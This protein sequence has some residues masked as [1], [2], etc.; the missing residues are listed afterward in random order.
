MDQNQPNVSATKLRV[1]EISGRPFGFEVS[2][3]RGKLYL[4][5]RE[6]YNPDPDSHG[7]ATLEEAAKHL[8]FGGNGVSIRVDGELGT[9]AVLEY[10]RNML[11]AVADA[12]ESDYASILEELANGPG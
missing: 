7:Y 10:V 8:R 3:F 9:D 1:V 2:E 11:Q 5:G 12:T 6:M 4:T